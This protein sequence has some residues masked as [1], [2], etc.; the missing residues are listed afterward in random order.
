MLQEAERCF[1]RVID[2]ATCNVCSI[3]HMLALAIVL[4][5]YLETKRYTEARRVLTTM[6]ELSKSYIG[7]RR[8]V[9]KAAALLSQQQ[10]RW[11]Q[12]NHSNADI[13]SSALGIFP[14]DFNVFCGTGDAATSTSRQP[15]PQ[16]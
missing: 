3:N 14:D 4:K 12:D 8:I 15:P 1:E 11:L 6:D 2:R 5:I 10:Q 9:E 7:T 13:A 16:R